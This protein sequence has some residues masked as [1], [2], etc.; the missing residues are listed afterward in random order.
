MTTLLRIPFFVLLIG[1]HAHAQQPVMNMYDTLPRQSTS[2][3]S[4][5]LFIGPTA[6]NYRL[7]PSMVSFAGTPRYD[8]FDIET[9]GFTGTRYA[10]NV[11]IGVRTN[12]SFM[13]NVHFSSDYNIQAG[14]IGVGYILD[15][16]L[17]EDAGLLLAVRLDLAGAQL[18]E[19][20]KQSVRPSR[21]EVNTFG[22]LAS[23]EIRQYVN[24]FFGVYAGV[25]FYESLVR[26]RSLSMQKDYLFVPQYDQ[27][28]SDT[29]SIKQGDDDPYRL[30]LMLNAG[31]VFSFK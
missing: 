24:H 11:G 13:Y 22:L 26:Y 27:M 14:S 4:I 31:L 12:N 17:L 28:P 7:S 18:V 2:N 3:A 16:G 1:L 9:N 8:E 30:R 21:V 6:I 25:S 20:S 5:D 10:F 19:I 15:R 29:Y 23:F